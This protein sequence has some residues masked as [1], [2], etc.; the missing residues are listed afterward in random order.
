M[1]RHQDDADTDSATSV[2]TDYH[3]M[4][5]QKNSAA[6][7]MNI[8]MKKIKSIIRREKNRQSAANSRK[9][10]KEYIEQLENEN[11]RLRD[12]ISDII[13][14][15]KFIVKRKDDEP[16]AYFVQPIKPGG[17]G[18]E[19][20]MSSLLPPVATDSNYSCHELRDVFS[21]SIKQE[22]KHHFEDHLTIEYFA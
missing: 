6:K 17:G 22:E 15:T 5:P 21:E 9:R 14:H 11:Q 7:K 18:E 1:N 16:G 2:V 19:E 3:K 8:E 13:S 10:I 4:P 12:L 20:Q